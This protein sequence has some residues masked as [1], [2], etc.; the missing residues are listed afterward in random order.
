MSGEV[1][2][3]ECRQ[4]VP[5]ESAIQYGNAFVCAACK[6]RFVQ[7]LREG[8]LLPGDE[9]Q[10]AYAG[11]WIR[12]VAT[13]VDAV[14]ELIITYPVLIAVYGWGYLTDSDSDFREG[15]LDLFLSWIFPAL[16]TVAF[17]V[18][19]QATPG[20]MLVRVKIVDAR[21]GDRPSLGQ[22]IIR[23]LMY[24]PS[25]LV[26]ALGF[27]WVAFDK[28]KQGWHDKVAKTIVIRPNKPRLR[29]T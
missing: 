3:A 1:V 11:F 16:V 7:R 15:P 10:F 4:V 2:C 18:W 17:W 21:T 26:L 12:F 14:L 6:P 27:I 25:F 8:A 13:M 28:R 19:K 9:P 20:K 5:S 23:Y 22:F 29:P 24:F